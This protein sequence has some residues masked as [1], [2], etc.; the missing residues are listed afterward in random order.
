MNTQK[1][2]RIANAFALA[3]VSVLLLQAINAWANITNA[4]NQGDWISLKKVAVAAI[5]AA[6]VAGLRAV[7]SYVIGV[8][9]PEPAENAK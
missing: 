2:K 4:V 1:L 6:L 7:Q 3:F 9:S 8:P 5:A